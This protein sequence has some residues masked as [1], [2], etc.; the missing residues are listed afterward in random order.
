[1][2]VYGHF[3]PGDRFDDAFDPLF[4]FHFIFSRIA[5]AVSPA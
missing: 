3:A 5:C 1:L 4:E 2:G